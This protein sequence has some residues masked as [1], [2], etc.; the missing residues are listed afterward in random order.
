MNFEKLLLFTYHSMLILLAYL[1]NLRL[2]RF[3]KEL[4]LTS[5]K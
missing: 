3:L 4:Q 2:G 1:G 5:F